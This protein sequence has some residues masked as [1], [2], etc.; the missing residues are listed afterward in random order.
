VSWVDGQGKTLARGESDADGRVA[1]RRKTGRARVL[2]ARKATDV[3]DRPQG[4]GARP[5]RIRHRRHA[6]RPVRLFAYSGRNLYRPGE[7]FEVS[8]MARDADGHPV[9]PQP[10]QAIL[11]RPDGK[12]QWTATWQPD[13]AFAGYYRRAIELPADAATGSWNLE[14][15][16]DPAPRWPAPACLSPSRNS[17]RRE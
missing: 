8:V 17:C 3:A 5:R 13:P 6:L 2:M 11:R 12:A 9:P 7:R 16:A 15:R 4:A 14:L 1:L 10:I